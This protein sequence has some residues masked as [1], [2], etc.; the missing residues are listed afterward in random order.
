MK[1][2][3]IMIVI[4]S[5]ILA[6]CAGLNGPNTRELAQAQRFE[7]GQP[8]PEGDNF[9][10]HFP[11]G[12]PLP[13]ATKVSGNLF[14]QE[15]QSMAHVTLK[16]DIYTFRQFVSWDGKKWQRSDNLIGINLE[17]Q[18]PPKDGG[19]AGLLHVKLNQK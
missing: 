18:I 9:I 6:A 11:A 7:V 8:L 13:V 15:A 2:P 1:L 12:T 17:L 14:E 19:N 5:V 4:T 10:L 16:R 3:T